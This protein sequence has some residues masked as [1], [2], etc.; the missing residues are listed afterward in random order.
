MLAS[1]ILDLLEIEPAPQ[2]CDHR[3]GIVCLVAFVIENI[4][5]VDAV[6][7]PPIVTALHRPPTEIRPHAPLCVVKDRTHGE[8]AWRL[9][10]T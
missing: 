3:I 9:M 2:R 7:P 4:L 8:P 1:H 5:V 6:D 10:L